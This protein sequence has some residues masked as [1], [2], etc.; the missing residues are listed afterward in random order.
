MNASVS[1]KM[2]ITTAI[3]TTSVAGLSSVPSTNCPVGKAVQL[4]GS[5][6]WARASIMPMPDARDT[7]QGSIAALARSG[8]THTWTVL[9][10]GT[11]EVG[12]RVGPAAYCDA[13]GE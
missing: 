1:Q 9:G 4:V 2:A 12:C 5:K 3:Q 13:R 6:Y 8:G 10:I 7:F 11:S